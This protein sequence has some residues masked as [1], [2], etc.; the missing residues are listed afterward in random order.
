MIK[1]ICERYK[2]LVQG[3][4]SCIDSS[5]IRGTSGC[6]SGEVLMSMGVLLAITGALQLVVVS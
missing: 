1:R 3:H 2:H 4:S 5:L 6:E